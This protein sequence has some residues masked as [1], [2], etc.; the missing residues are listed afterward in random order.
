MKMRRALVIGLL[1]ALVACSAQ[2][3]EV[4]SSRTTSAQAQSADCAPSQLAFSLDNGNGRF[5]GMSHSGTTLVLRNN[6]DV[7]LHH[8][9]TAADFHGYRQADA[10]HRRAGFA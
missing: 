6:R 4:S 8:F 3:P 7:H 9:R 1:L 2:P 5:N 10:G